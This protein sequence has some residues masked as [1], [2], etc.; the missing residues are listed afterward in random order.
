MHLVAVEQPLGA[1]PG[2]LIGLVVAIFDPQVAIRLLDRAA[3]L[4]VLLVAVLADGALQRVAVVNP[5]QRPRRADGAR[6]P[7]VQVLGGSVRPR[8]EL[9]GA[10]LVL[11][12]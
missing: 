4:V 11:L 2:L 6:Q 10:D 5:R 7:R 9:D 1:R 8:P 3:R 12:L